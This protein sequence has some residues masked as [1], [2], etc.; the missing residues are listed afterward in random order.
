MNTD[1]YD[2]NDIKTF[3]QDLESFKDDYVSISN[4]NPN[5]LEKR[6]NDYSSEI[7]DKWN[8][9]GRSL[10]ALTERIKILTKEHS[11]EGINTSHYFWSEQDLE[12][13]ISGIT[14]L[15]HHHSQLKSDQ[16]KVPLLTKALE[17]V[18]EAYDSLHKAAA[19]NHEKRSSQTQQSELEASRFSLAYYSNLKL[20]KLPIH[21]NKSSQS[22]EDAEV[23]TR[24]KVFKVELKQTYQYEQDPIEN[25]I[26][27]LVVS[28]ALSAKIPIEHEGKSLEVPKQF[29]LDLRRSDLLEVDGKEVFKKGQKISIFE[30]CEKFIQLVG[31]K[32]FDRLGT[33]LTQA[34]GAMVI[35][36]LLGQRPEELLD[37]VFSNKGS[38][39]KH[40][41]QTNKS[42]IHVQ[43]EFTLNCW[44]STLAGTKNDVPLGYIAV[45]LDVS[46]PRKEFDQN[47][48]ELDVDKRLPNVQATLS[49]SGFYP[50]QYQAEKALNSLLYRKL[51]KLF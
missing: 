46:V 38:S 14:I 1:N 39:L 25:E 35:G 20:P 42:H 16:D 32:T 19:V 41:V 27:E 24:E 28:P 22:V 51:T 21:F 45:R 5:A 31:K 10:T 49:Y 34:F 3:I 26:R 29:E 13:A 37:V 50:T 23:T 44:D 40:F 30:S 18:L 33:I 15:L 17:D 12:K 2:V 36:K 7:L 9:T 6:I 43:S 47:L 8:S 4:I 48:E 11:N